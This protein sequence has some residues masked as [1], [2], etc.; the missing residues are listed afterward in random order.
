M[1]DEWNPAS[2]L[3]ALKKASSFDVF[4][5]S[6]IAL[7]FVFNAWLGIA[8]KLQ[9]SRNGRLWLL[10]VVLILY[11]AGMVAMFVGNSR[12]RQREIA[13]DQIIGYLASKGYTMVSFEKIRSRI[14]REYAD[15]FLA[16][17][18]MFFPDVLR[19][20]RLKGGR[21]GIAKI[22]PSDIQDEG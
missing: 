11:A 10:S 13:R 12:M 6:F 5:I 4:L 18:P 9:I 17:L 16:N 20:A 21:P 2:V 7:P 22:E 8:D 1:A 15:A 14:N 3:H 19:R